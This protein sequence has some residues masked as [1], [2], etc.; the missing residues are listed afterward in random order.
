MARLAGTYLFA[1]NLEGADLSHACLNRAYLSHANLQNANLSRTSLISADLT[2]VNWQSARVQAAQFGNNWGLTELRYHRL[3]QQSAQFLGQPRF[4]RAQQ[5]EEAMRQLEEAQLD[6]ED[7]L[8]C[9]NTVLDKWR[10]GLSQVAQTSRLRGLEQ[11]QAIYE[12][13]YELFVQCQSYCAS[14]AETLPHS[15]DGAK[16]DQFKA[17]I[18]Q[19]H[20]S[21]L[22]L[23]QE[24]S[25]NV[26]FEHSD[27][28]HTFNVLIR[29]RRIESRFHSNLLTSASP[30]DPEDIAEPDLETVEVSDYMAQNGLLEGSIEIV[31]EGEETE[32]D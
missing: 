10:D 26:A 1:A 11:L 8:I 9:L 28:A 3:T 18:L 6:L 16:L 25:R 29:V 22:N 21:I 13:E 32:E 30:D 5:R 19:I 23:T 31:E 2:G 27:I 20:W 24:C 17:F 14:L 15:L 12:S 4:S 7:R